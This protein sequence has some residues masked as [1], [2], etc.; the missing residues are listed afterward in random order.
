MNSATKLRFYWPFV[1]KNSFTISKDGQIFLQPKDININFVTIRLILLKT[2]IN[3]YYDKLSPW[4]H[5]YRLP[6]VL[7]CLDALACGQAIPAPFTC[8]LVNHAHIS[9]CVVSRHLYYVLIETIRFAVFAHTLSWGRFHTYRLSLGFSNQLRFGLLLKFKMVNSMSHRVERPTT[10]STWS[11]AKF[12]C[13]SLNVFIIL[14]MF[15][16]TVF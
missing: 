9:S 3:I 1:E 5:T 14:L 12:R 11:S 10:W 16:K 8:L 4:R 6:P 15:G 2:T 7:K 13:N